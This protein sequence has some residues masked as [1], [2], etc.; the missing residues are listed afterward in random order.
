LIVGNCSRSCAWQWN[1]CVQSRSVR[2]L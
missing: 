2:G 1:L